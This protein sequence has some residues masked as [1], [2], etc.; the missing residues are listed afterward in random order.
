LEAHWHKAKS[1]F[2]WLSTGIQYSRQLSLLGVTNFGFAR[3]AKGNFETIQ[4]LRRI[5]SI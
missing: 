1:T 2:W 5:G 3:E 4:V